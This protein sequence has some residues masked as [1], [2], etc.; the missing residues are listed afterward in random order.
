MAVD[1]QD[2]KKRLWANFQADFKKAIFKKSVISVFVLVTLWNLSVATDLTTGWLDGDGPI[3]ETAREIRDLNLHIQMRFYQ[4]LTSVRAVPLKPDNIRLVYIDN[5]AHWM[6]LGGELPTSRVFLAQLIKEMS[7]PPHA[8]SAIGI[9]IEMLAPMGRVE[10]DDTDARRAGDQQLLQEIRA[11]SARGVPVILASGYY[12]KNGRK[13]LIP[14][15]LKES[16]LRPN[17]GGG[18]GM[19]R[20]PGFGFVNLPSDKRQIPLEEQ[21]WSEENPPKKETA[22]SF[23]LALAM[24][25]TDV[26]PLRADL[27]LS[28]KQ[29]ANEERFG[30]F[31]PEKRYTVVYALNL[32]E[33]DEEALANITNKIVLVGGHWQDMQGHGAMVDSHLSPAGQMSGLGLHA[34]YIASL[35]QEK[36]AR[37]FPLWAGI[38]LDLLIGLVIYLG[39]EYGEGRRTWIILVVAFPLPILGAYF[40]LANANRYL[41]FL[42]PVELYFL[43]VGYSLAEPHLAER[44]EKLSKRWHP[45]AATGQQA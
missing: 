33:E 19:P 35:L 43:H 25:S 21:V 31:L 44:W 8:A 36:Y 16:D 27:G 3:R 26:K 24:L 14:N 42:F 30:S 1:E 39:F 29:D 13:I 11:A 17:P 20:C 22:E 18:C 5:T 4:L 34:N 2:W 12:M 45:A 32:L 9:D 38:L 15:V 40:C 6:K 10:G 7:T 23:A 28:E 41:D 37:E